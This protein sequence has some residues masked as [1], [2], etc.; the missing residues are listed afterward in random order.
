[1]EFVWRCRGYS[2]NNLRVADVPSEIRKE[3]L[4][5]RSIA[6]CLHKKI[7]VPQFSCIKQPYKYGNNFSIIFY[8]FKNRK[9]N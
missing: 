8:Y 2:R 6:S 1:M 7:S 3:H 4:G 5:D 9:K